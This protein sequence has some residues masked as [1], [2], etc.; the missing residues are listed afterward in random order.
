MRTSH[1][2]CCLAISFTSALALASDKDDHQHHQH[3]QHHQA[4]PGAEK[5]AQVDHSKHQMPAAQPPGSVKVKY[6]DSVLTDQNG[7]KVKLKSEL[8]RDQIV[9]MDFAY[10][11]CTTVCP[12]LTALM[13][14]VQNGLA[15]SGPAGVQ[16]ITMTVDPARD[17][18]SRLR[19]YAQKH[20]AKPG[21]VWLTGPTGRVNEVLKGFDA[22]SPS[23]EDH[24]PLV[25]V[26]DPVS[27]SWTRFVGFTDPQEL[28]A[29]VRELHA[30]RGA[31]K[32]AGHQH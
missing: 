30:A 13:V 21:W 20:G 16:L 28:L 2:A 17:T 27:G 6:G 25:L 31:G 15:E 8:I 32:Q 7:R 9:V 3:H 14:K 1:I 10:T 19:A 11:S 18:A 24:P 4:A 23:F 12:V 29:K 5:D 26:G 22:Y